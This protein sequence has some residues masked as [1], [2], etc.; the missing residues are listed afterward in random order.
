MPGKLLF[1]LITMCLNLRF[2]VL[3]ILIFALESA[4]IFKGKISYQ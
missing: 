2:E 4:Y 1:I 3:E